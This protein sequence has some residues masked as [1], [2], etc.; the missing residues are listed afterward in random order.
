MNHTIID[1]RDSGLKVGDEVT[2]ISNDPS[3]MNSVTGI[4]AKFGCFEYTTVINL[5]DGIRRRIV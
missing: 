3:R 4:E 2:V 5:S 1:L